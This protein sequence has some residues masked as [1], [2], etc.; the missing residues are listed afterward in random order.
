MRTIIKKIT[1]ITILTLTLLLAV[2]LVQSQTACQATDLTC[3]S[4]PI[5]ETGFG[6]V[7]ICGECFPCGVPDGV[8]PEKYTDGQTELD[9]NKTHVLFKI[10]EGARPPAI[11]NNAAYRT[12]ND[13][14]D[15]CS[16]VTDGTC[17]RIHTYPA[18]ANFQD[19]YTGTGTEHLCT[20]TGNQNEYAVAEC[21]NVKRT[22]GC[23]WC[24]DPDCVANVQG[25]TW[26]SSDNTTIEANV[27]IVSDYNYRIESKTKSDPT[28]GKYTLQS[29]TGNVKFVCTK[30]DYIPVTKS[31]YIH[32]NIGTNTVDCSLKEAYCTPEC[33]M[34]N[35]QGTE[36]CR[37]NCDGKNGCRYNPLGSCIGPTTGTSYDPIKMCEGLESGT[38]KSLEWANSEHTEIFY[39]NC[40]TGTCETGSALTLDIQADDNIKNLVTKTYSKKING[41]PVNLKI[42]VYEKNI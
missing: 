42:I 2:S 24:V 4:H 28:T 38:R 26:S 41:E 39:M 36:V 20:Y 8:C 32:D 23:Q 33:T 11:A 14:N 29:P 34:P 21:N 6:A 18:T 31:V 19:I 3:G 10:P 13:G 12:A 17:A 7:Q 5:T 1:I 22:A 27:N 16:K 35:A 9:F 40:C 25:V 15:A 37:P 30:E